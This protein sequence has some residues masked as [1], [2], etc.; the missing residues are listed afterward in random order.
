MFAPGV[1]HN[2]VKLARR[3]AIGYC[4]NII[5]RTGTCIM[6]ITQYTPFHIWMS[7][8]F[9]WRSPPMSRTARCC[10]Q[11]HRP[12]LDASSS[13]ASELSALGMHCCRLNLPQLTCIPMKT[14]VSAC[15]APGGTDRFLALEVG[16]GRLRFLRYVNFLMNPKLVDSFGKSQARGFHVR[17]HP[18]S[19]WSDKFH[20][21]F[22]VVQ[23]GA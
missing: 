4:H 20:P 12:H 23:F 18:F 13:R 19:S 17:C 15:T 5:V 1:G 11:R 7:W 10:V 22:L 21:I 14:A 6:A 16:A 2:S 8:P 3:S 9:H